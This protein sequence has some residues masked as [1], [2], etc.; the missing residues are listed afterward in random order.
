MPIVKLQKHTSCRHY[1][2]PRF[3]VYG[4]SIAGAWFHLFDA[5]VNAAALR[6]EI[7]FRENLYNPNVEVRLFSKQDGKWGIMNETQVLG[8]NRVVVPYIIIMKSSL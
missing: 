4:T 2:L 6:E 3:R 1:S 8:P 7:L 5:S